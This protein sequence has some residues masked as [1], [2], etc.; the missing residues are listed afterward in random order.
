MRTPFEF[1]SC[2]EVTV[3]G[4]RFWAQHGLLCG[5]HLP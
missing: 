5:A 4:Y 2:H 3:K 1:R